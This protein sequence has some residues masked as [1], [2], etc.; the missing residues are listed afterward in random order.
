MVTLV[1]DT[2][3]SQHCVYYIIFQVVA[4]LAEVKQINSFIL[5]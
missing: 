4:D 1:A 5:K 3:K 2:K